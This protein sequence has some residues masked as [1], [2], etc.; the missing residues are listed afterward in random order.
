M[1]RH[2]ACVNKAGG[3]E[4]KTGRQEHDGNGMK[5]I[6]NRFKIITMDHKPHIAGDIDPDEPLTTL[7]LSPVDLTHASPQIVDPP[8]LELPLPDPGACVNITG[9]TEFKTG[10]REHDGNGI[11]K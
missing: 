4:F 5:K 9:G 7:A 3:T 6:G 2:R 11:K 10:R 1:S 8:E